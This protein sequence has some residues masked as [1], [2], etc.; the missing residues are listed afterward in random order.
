MKLSLHKYITSPAAKVVL[1]ALLIALVL[2]GLYMIHMH[3]EPVRDQVAA[4]I[5]KSD[6]YVFRKNV[7]EFEIPAKKPA[8][9]KPEA[10]PAPEPYVPEE[11]QKPETPSKPGTVVVPDRNRKS[12]GRA[13]TRGIRPIQET[14]L[15]ICLYSAAQSGTT[16]VADG[17]DIAPFGRKIRCEL[18]NTIST[19]SLQTPI[20]ALVTEPLWWDGV[21]IIPAGVEVHGKVSGGPARDRIGAA[22]TWTVVYPFRDG[23]SAYQMQLTGTVLACSNIDGVWGDE[24]GSAGIIGIVKGN[25]DNAKL[26]GFAAKFIS[27]LGSGMVSQDYNTWGTVSTTGGTWKDSLGKGLE[28]AFSEY[29]KDILAQAAKELTYVEAQ[30]GTEFYIYVEQ[31]IDPSQAKRG[32]M[33][34]GNTLTDAA[35][36]SGSGTGPQNSNSKSRRK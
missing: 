3:K 33:T 31:I 5:K 21:E 35:D 36:P 1:F 26:A 13:I 19:G 9:A 2:C 30:A 27:G 25:S 18:A 17:I 20:I 6:E 11:V 23:R 32:K 15:P 4:T 10:E 7:K 8:P 22:S 16:T 28:S 14:V 34:A 24:D 12:S 29:A